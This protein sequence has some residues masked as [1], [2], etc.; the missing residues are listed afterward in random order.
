[1]SSSPGIVDRLLRRPQPSLRH[2]E[3]C[4]PQLKLLQR[5]GVGGVQLLITP[6]IRSCRL[7]TG[8]IGIAL[9]FVVAR[10]EPGKEPAPSHPLSLHD[11]HLYDEP[12]NLEGQLGPLGRFDR[13]GILAY[14]GDTA[15]AD[16]D[17]LHRPRD[18][19]LRRRL[20]A[21]SGNE[22]PDGR[23]ESQRAQPRAVFQVH[24]SNP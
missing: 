6:I 24:G 19:L 15:E 22:R 7:E 18:H 23:E 9:R 10:I 13:P 3:L 20:P 8:G 5:H 17:H 12:G 1:L 16:L 11:R 2:F 4:L 21:A 14:A